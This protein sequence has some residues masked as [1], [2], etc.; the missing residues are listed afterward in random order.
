M[1]SPAQIA[2]LTGKLGG[3][4]PGKSPGFVLEEHTLTGILGEE[5]ATPTDGWAKWAEVERRQRESVTVLQGY[6]AYK[7]TLPLLLDAHALG[8]SDV[9]GLVSILEWF[10]GRGTLFQG[11]PGAAGVGESPLLELS[12][13][14]DLVPAWMQSGRGREG[15]TYYVLQGPIEYNMFGREF[16]KPAR[17]GSGE[18]GAGRRIRQAANLTLMAYVGTSADTSDS[19]A[20]RVNILRKQE[21]TYVSFTVGDSI[22]TFTRIAKHFNRRDPARIPDAAREIQQANTKYGAS[23]NKNLPRGARIKV[24]ESATGKRF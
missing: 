10:G 19:V 4:T 17:K 3:L 7:I 18:H 15:Q 9:E 12:S 2:T 14:S 22:N 6:P 13:E 16:I 20:N 23:V 21:E 24:P 5:G 11:K 8:V 1:I